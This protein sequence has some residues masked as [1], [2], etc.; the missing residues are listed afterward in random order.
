MG[1]DVCAVP[2]GAARVL[3]RSEVRRGVGASDGKSLGF[4]HRRPAVLVMFVGD[5]WSCFGAGM[6]KL[7]VSLG[8]L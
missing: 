8:G 7:M 6:V 5:A 4:R 1:A 3:S 2:G